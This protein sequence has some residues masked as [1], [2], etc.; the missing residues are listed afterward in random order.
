MVLGAARAGTRIVTVGEHGIVML[1]DD[2]GRT[3]RQARDVRTR[4]T[5]NDVTFVNAR[6]GW[7]VGHAGVILHTIDGG[8]T[9]MRQRADTTT[10]QPLFSIAFTDARHGVAVGLW[11]LAL[12]SDDGGAHWTAVPLPAGSGKNN[13]D[14]L[15]LYSVTR[16][17]SQSGLLV[18]AEQGVVFMSSDAGKSWRRAD[19]GYA[20]SLWTGSVSPAGTLYVAGLRGRV[21]QS[22]DSGAS[23]QQCSSQTQ[24]SIARLVAGE[25]GIIG[26]GL[27][28]TE[29]VLSDGTCR[30]DVKR[31]PSRSTFTAAVY[32]RNGKAI[33]FSK[34]G[35][36]ESSPD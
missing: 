28:G 15:N 32:D 7:A 18:T 19:T 14:R 35:V 25:S 36:L 17:D 24:S 9:W 31:W 10:D 13:K 29:I 20:G 33:L 4:A 2:D 16:T 27:D 5:L 11:S 12:R 26:V 6:E 22:R 3:F 1:S 34:D 30:F 8:E 21:Y 23:W